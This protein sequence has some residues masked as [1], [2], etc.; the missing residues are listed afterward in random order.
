GRIA[1]NLSSRQLNN[2]ALAEQVE[3]ALQHH[4]LPG[5][6]L[7]CEITESMVVQ[8]GGV[9]HGNLEA[10]ASMGIDLAI[11]DFGTGHSSL[12]NL[13]RFPLRRLKID[14]SFVDGL[15]DDANDEAIAGASI[16]LAKQLGFDVVAEGV[17]TQEQVEFL[18]RHHCDVVQGYL[19]AKPM[20]AGEVYDRFHDTGT[21][22]P[23]QQTDIP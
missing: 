22:P 14:R 23:H 13:K 15:G 8:E 1:I 4:E 6:I 17:E 3:R 5:S 21:A 11:D 2:P 18:K 12:V 19:F 9:A 16:A 10:F 7:E 20:T